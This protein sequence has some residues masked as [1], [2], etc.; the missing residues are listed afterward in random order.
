VCAP[1][2]PGCVVDWV[3]GYRVYGSN[4]GIGSAA[5]FGQLGHLTGHGGYLYTGNSNAIRRIEIAT[6][7]VETIAGAPGQ[8]GDLTGIGSSARFGELAG[9]ATDGAT[10]WVSDVTYQRI[11][12]V[13]LSTNEVMNV[14]TTPGAARGLTYDGSFLYYVAPDAGSGLFRVDAS[15]GTT[16]Q[17][18]GFLGDGYVDGASDLAQFNRPRCLLAFGADNLLVSDTEND[19]IRG[20]DVTLTDASANLST[21]ITWAGAIGGGYLDGAN[22]LAARFERLRGLHA[23]DGRLFVADSD[24]FVIRQVILESGAVTTIA[25]MANVSNAHRE[26]VGLEAQFNKPVDVYFD[27]VTKDLFIAEDAVIRRMYDP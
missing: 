6:A 12:A 9:V 5:S 15:D 23:A 26:G 1:Q 10:L 27:L 13:N 7:N 20:V 3:G 24:N 14:A 2:D 8:A 19:V 16:V 18:A 11:R 25:G 21:V 17:V 4:D 22:R